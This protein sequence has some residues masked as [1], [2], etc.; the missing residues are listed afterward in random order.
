MAVPRLPVVAASIVALAMICV[1]GC[2]NNVEVW[3]NRPGPKVLAFFPP[4]Y[5]LA[6]QVAGDDAQ[7]QS[8]LTSKGPHDFEFRASD[9]RKLKQADL[10]LVV[11]LGLSD[12]VTNRLAEAANNP[13]MKVV[14]LGEC[15]PK[16]QRL[17]A[18]ACCCGH[19]HGD[20]DHAGHDHAHGEFDPH[21]WLGIPEAIIMVN[22]IRDALTQA[23]PAHK[24]GYAKRS[25][26]LTERLLKLQA[27]GQSLIAAK[28]KNE[29]PRLLTHHDAMR[30]FA[31]SF[32]AEVADAIEMPG[33]EPSGKRL[34]EL[35]KLCKEKNVRLIA[36]EPQ[37]PSRTGAQT[38]LRELQRKGI[39]DA[40]FV[41]L[42]TLEVADPADLTPDYYE[43]R[44]RHN[45]ENLAG[46]LK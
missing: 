28:S 6:A 41:E 29:K 7:V 38:L 16:D 18:G 30:Y 23:D 27:E 45:L 14:R 19:D 39:P 43:R 11:G 1:G 40:A 25:A 17:P 12:D 5:S 8:L 22:A 13:N 34:D 37:Y 24:D 2:S 32:G 46:A 33:R 42:D 3:Q 15:I 35:I 9:A 21:V 20:G 44:M 4:I 31:R 26:E 10:F 36:V